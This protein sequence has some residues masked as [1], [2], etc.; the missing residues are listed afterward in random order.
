MKV[1]FELIE[2]SLALKVTK[3]NGFQCL[4][5]NTTLQTKNL[6]CSWKSIKIFVFDL[7]FPVT[8]DLW[9]LS[10]TKLISDFSVL[11]FLFISGQFTDIESPIFNCYRYL[12][13][14]V[15][16]LVLLKFKIKEDIENIDKITFFRAGRVILLCK[17]RTKLLIILLSIF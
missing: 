8:L 10:R 6:F 16:V 1:F 12:K 9:V 14:A 17:W 11:H 4:D 7:L 3:Q 5:N 2:A 15:Y 13:R